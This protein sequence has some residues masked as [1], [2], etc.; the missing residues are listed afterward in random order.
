MENKDL[1]LKKYYLESNNIIGFLEGF[2]K[3]LPVY[4]SIYLKKFTDNR[5]NS[6]SVF[7]DEFPFGEVIDDIGNIVKNSKNRFE[8]L[9]YHS[10]LN[11]RN[12]FGNRFILFSKNGDELLKPFYNLYWE[13]PL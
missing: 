4:L 8:G 3:E 7:D 9:Y 12:C 10:I 1:F 5:S 11:K 2:E 6:F 13:I